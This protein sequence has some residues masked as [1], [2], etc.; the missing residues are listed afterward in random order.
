MHYGTYKGL[1]R[2]RNLIINTKVELIKNLRTNY[3]SLYTYCRSK[4]AAATIKA[5]KEFG[6]RVEG[7]IDDNDSFT[8]SKFLK[9]KTIN[10]KMFFK[11][12]KKKLSKT[13]VLITHQRIKTF[14]KISRQL[15]KRGLKKNQIMMIKY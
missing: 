6:Y 2:Y 5:L 7:V 9:Y 10:S 14:K 8:K 12:N 11:K 3:K 1:L 13:I 4:Y 15:I